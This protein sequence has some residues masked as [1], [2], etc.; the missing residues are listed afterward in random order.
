MSRCRHKKKETRRYVYWYCGYCNRGWRIMLMKICVPFAL[1]VIAFA[2]LCQEVR[3][4]G[5]APFE[6]LACPFVRSFLPGTSDGRPLQCAPRPWNRKR[7][8][9]T[10]L[11]PLGLWR[12]PCSPVLEARAAA[13]VS[14]AYT[15]HENPLSSKLD[16]VNDM[17]YALDAKLRKRKIPYSSQYSAHSSISRIFN[18]FTSH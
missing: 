16:N 1:T 3:A 13:L 17:V 14:N 4:N 7:G 8:A 9:T 10:L 12:N 11:V 15:K 5:F 6:N 2:R 18:T